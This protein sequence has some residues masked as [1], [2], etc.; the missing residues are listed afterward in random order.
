MPGSLGELPLPRCVVRID[1]LRCRGAAAN[2]TRSVPA[3]LGKQKQPTGLAPAAA[4]VVRDARSE[5]LGLGEL[6][7]ALAAERLAE[8]EK[9]AGLDLAD[10]L[11]SDA[12]LA[13]H[14]FQRARLA[15]LEA[16]AHLDHLSLARRQRPQD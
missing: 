11:A 1:P 7:E 16:E 12:V 6:G 3:T 15:V 13:G 4:C 8:L 9:T 10:A 14:L 5:S 2:G